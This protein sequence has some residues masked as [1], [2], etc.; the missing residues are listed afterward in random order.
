[1]YVY[2]LASEML[3]DFLLH[4]VLSSPNALLLKIVKKFEILRIK[5]IVHGKI[6][7][8]R[9]ELKFGSDYCSKKMP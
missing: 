4:F 5:D 6:R 3:F 8:F 1:M 2:E 9:I 7:G